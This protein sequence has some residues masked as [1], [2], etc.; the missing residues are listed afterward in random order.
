M[1]IEHIY[2]QYPQED[3]T[4]VFT[5][6]SAAEAT[7]DGGA[8]IFIRYKDGEEE[9]A[10]P[11]GKYSTN[12]RAEREALSEAATA[13]LQNSARTTGSVVVFSDALSVLQALNNSRS[14]ELNTLTTALAAL[15]A[16]VE[17]IVL[18]WVP[19]HCDII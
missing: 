1:A 16:R 4:H 11:T 12:F 19:A 13:V 14:K 18:Q 3:W 2:Q 10:F 6:G 7:K 17:K 8:G 5:D 9:L 15:G